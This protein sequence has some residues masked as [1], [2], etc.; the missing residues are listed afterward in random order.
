MTDL[1]KRGTLK[2]LFNLSDEQAIEMIPEAKPEPLPPLTEQVV[3][4]ENTEIAAH[5]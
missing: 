2:I 1:Q 3:L 4:S 5:A